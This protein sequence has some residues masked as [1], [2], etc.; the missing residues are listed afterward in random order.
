MGV[1][2]REKEEAATEKGI[3]KI[4]SARPIFTLLLPNNPWNLKV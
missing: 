2:A 3:V 1:A 4:F